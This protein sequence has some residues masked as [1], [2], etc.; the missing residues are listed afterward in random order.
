M[1]ETLKVGDK[2]PDFHAQDQDGAAHTLDDY[3]GKWLVV[4]FY[5]KDHTPGCIRE[6]CGMRDNY[7]DIKKLAEIVGVSGDSVKSHS[8]F[9]AKY[10]LPFTL[11]ADPEKN[12]LDSYGT[13]GILLNKRSTFII[14]PEGNIA[15]IY[16]K[17]NP[18]AHASQI[19]AD[20]EELAKA[21]PSL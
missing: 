15:K 18:D 1:S 17:V 10:E 7:G 8:G 11:L 14:D 5:P 2:A 12:I 20:L 6:A 13:N 9:A 19:I 4:Y 16:E 3:S 21:K